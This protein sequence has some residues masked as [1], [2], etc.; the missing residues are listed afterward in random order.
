MTKNRAVKD[1]KR[2]KRKKAERLRGE[3]RKLDNVRAARLIDEG[4]DQGTARGLAA[5]WSIPKAVLHA[6]KRGEPR[7]AITS[8]PA[9]YASIRACLDRSGTTEYVEQYIDAMYDM[10]A[11]SMEEE[12]GGV[13]FVCHED[14]EGSHRTAVGMPAGLLYMSPAPEKWLE[15]YL[16][17]PSAQAVAWL[18]WRPS[19]SIVLALDKERNLALWFVGDDFE[20]HAAAQAQEFVTAAS[21][22]E[23]KKPKRDLTKLFDLCGIE[24]GPDGPVASADDPRAVR[25]LQVYRHCQR[26]ALRAFLGAP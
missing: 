21:K 3:Q 24:H 22:F 4:L 2:E 12:V 14:H 7:C 23:C 10:H 1:R 9:Y 8:A 6:E 25:A 17:S 15:H 19:A 26:D 5:L 16:S 20:W 11:L 13:A 18:V